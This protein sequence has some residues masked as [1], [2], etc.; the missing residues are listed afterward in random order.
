MTE[1]KKTFTDEQS[2][3]IREFEYLPETGDLCI[4]FKG[5]ARYLY[6]EVPHSVFDDGL[7]A[8]SIGKFFYANIKGKYE[9]IKL[10]PEKPQ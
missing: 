7:A 3:Q 1:L 8:E 2:S 9:Y 5:G 4:M 6:H 10:D